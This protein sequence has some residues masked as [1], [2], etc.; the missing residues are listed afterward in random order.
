MNKA[1]PKGASSKAVTPP[2]KRGM[3]TDD[4]ADDDEEVTPAAR[5]NLVKVNKHNL[6]PLQK[7]PGGVGVHAPP[8]PK[9]NSKAAAA[10]S[11]SGLQL[12]KLG[13]HLSWLE[14]LPFCF[15]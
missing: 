3:C 10:A 9:Q 7:M 5:P 4:D 8:L 12:Q 6:K 14:L 2:A 15:N 13:P 11:S 1:G